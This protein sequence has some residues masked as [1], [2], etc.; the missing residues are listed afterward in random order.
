MV[1]VCNFDILFRIEIREEVIFLMICDEKGVGGL[2]VGLVGKVML[3]FFG[4]FDSFVVGFYVMKCGLLVEVV[5]FFSLLY[6]SE[7]VK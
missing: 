3:M 7:C 5:Y 1:D 6:I 2:F 4:G